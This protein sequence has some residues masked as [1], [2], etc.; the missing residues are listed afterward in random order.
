[1][2]RVADGTDDFTMPWGDE[3]QRGV[4][5][6]KS[7]LVQEIC[8]ALCSSIALYE[9]IVELTS[10][11]LYNASKAL[12]FRVRQFVSLFLC[13]IE[14]RHYSYIVNFSLLQGSCE[15][16]FLFLSFLL[17]QNG[18]RMLQLIDDWSICCL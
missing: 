2:D 18:H 7:T 5:G 16:P 10:N 15:A 6:E 11:I 8:A 17:V 4:W 12:N 14:T 1:M 3:A 9:L 13:P